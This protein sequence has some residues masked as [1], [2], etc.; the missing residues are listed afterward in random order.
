MS[1]SEWTDTWKEEIRVNLPTSGPPSFKQK[2]ECYGS[3]V[4]NVVLP[5]CLTFIRRTSMYKKKIDLIKGKIDFAASSLNPY[6]KQG[7]R[8]C[9]S[10]SAFDQWDISTRNDIIQVQTPWFRWRGP[11]KFSTRA[12]D[13]C[14]FVRR[15]FRNELRRHTKMK[16]KEGNTTIFD[17]TREKYWTSISPSR[18]STT[19]LAG[20]PPYWS[21]CIAREG[22]NSADGNV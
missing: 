1:S 11:S 3:S 22:V 19:Y 10:T 12:S 15:M 7:S 4:R 5:F 6:M 13:W 17:R 2:E 20:R 8:Y 18:H 9:K 21:E 14:V 16:F